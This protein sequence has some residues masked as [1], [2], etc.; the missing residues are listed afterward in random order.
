[1]CVV[2]FIPPLSTG[3]VMCPSLYSI[4]IDSTRDVLYSL[5]HPYRHDPFMC[6]ILCSIPI[7]RTRDVCRVLYS[8]PIDTTRDVSLSRFPFNRPCSM[9]STEPRS[10]Q[11]QNHAVYK[12]KT[13]QTQNHAVYKHKT[14]QYTNTKPCSIQEI[15]GY[16]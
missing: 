15:K 11:T 8:T 5:L 10:I 9:Q 4:P 13:I 3:P 16:K 6:R 7:D 2:F 14:M 1:M 12:H